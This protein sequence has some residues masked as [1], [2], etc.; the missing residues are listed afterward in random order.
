MQELFII[1]DSPQSP[2][3]YKLLR[4]WRLVVNNGPCDRDTDTVKITRPRV[5]D[6]SNNY[7][8]I[9]VQHLKCA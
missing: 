4:R 8:K 5:T 9:K 2:D 3:I 1:A 6:A 7:A